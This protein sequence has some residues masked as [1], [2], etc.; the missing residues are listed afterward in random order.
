MDLLNKVIIVGNLTKDPEVRETSSGKAVAN[1]SLAVDPPGSRREGAGGRDRAQ[2]ETIFVEVVLW[3]K[4]A[5]NAGK[6][7]E[8]GS[9]VLIEGRLR[10]ESWE[11]KE[12]GKNRSKL[13]VVGE[14]M[15]FLNLGSGSG[16][17]ERRDP[18]RAQERGRSSAS[19]SRREPTGTRR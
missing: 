6:Y 16:R 7:L 11:D 18:D 5:E 1:L 15:R 10:M 2:E 9:P 13:K 8:K 4:T 3:E 19:P 17:D 14:R 12:T